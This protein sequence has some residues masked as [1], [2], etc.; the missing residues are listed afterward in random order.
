MKRRTF[1]RML[2]LAPVAAALPA[3]AL[4]RPEN[5]KETVKPTV[6]MDYAPGEGPFT[7]EAGGVRMSV[8]EPFDLDGFN[9]DLSASFKDAADHHR[10]LVNEAGRIADVP[11]YDR[12]KHG[13]D[14]DAWWDR[15]KS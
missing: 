2:G 10:Y 8:A 6:D 11:M 12:L 14:F 3:M 13:D 4:P 1:L 15:V 9:R 5:V 7:Y